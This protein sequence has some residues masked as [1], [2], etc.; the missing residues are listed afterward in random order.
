MSELS[1]TT[2]E[3][4]YEL[5]DRH[6]ARA[7][8]LAKA[9]AE[10]VTLQ[11][12]TGAVRLS[13]NYL[14]LPH[15]VALR[16][17]ESLAPYV[18]Y[19]LRRTANQA[20]QIVAEEEEAFGEGLGE[21]APF[22]PAIPAQDALLDPGGF[23]KGMAE[24]TNANTALTEEFRNF[25]RMGFAEEQLTRPVGRSTLSLNFSTPRG[26][27]GITV[28]RFGLPVH[29]F[30]KLPRQYTESIVW[31]AHE[32]ARRMRDRLRDQANNLRRGTFELADVA[33]GMPKFADLARQPELPGLYFPDEYDQERHDKFILSLREVKDSE[34]EEKETE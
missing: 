8:Y 18:A 32:G 27:L 12:P 23:P 3:L 14:L 15:D 20:R 10:R 24:D 5:V 11:T 19:G 13:T 28:D 34:R 4:A 6:N 17:H 22:V 16:E 2:L 9:A 21:A 29:L 26:E 25:V 1:G 30:S 31:M 33:P 7:D